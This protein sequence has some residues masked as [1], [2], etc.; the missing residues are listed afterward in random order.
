MGKVVSL[1]H[2][3]EENF[4]PKRVYV[5]VESGPWRDSFLMLKELAQNKRYVDKEVY[6]RYPFLNERNNVKIT[7]KL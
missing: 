2:K 4:L 5:K 7:V 6:K 1:N 3:R